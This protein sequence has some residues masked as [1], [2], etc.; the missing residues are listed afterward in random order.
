MK[1]NFF[2]YYILLVIAQVLIC[3]WF[4]LSAYVMLSILPA[5]V[6]CIPTKFSTTSSLLIAFATGFMVDFMAEGVIGLNILALVPVAAA[7]EHV[8]RFVFGEEPL[9][10]E[11][12]I[13]IRKYGIGKVIFSIVLVQS[14]F[15]LVY[16]IA[17]GAGARPF[18][19]NILRF[20]CSLLAGSALSVF[21]VDILTSEERR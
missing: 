7:R 11:D 15:L 21:I 5:L 13:S 19:F 2:L 3:E 8:I 12:S 14:L 1:Q 20:A 16:I 10:R 17:D 4:N 9:V 18:I 6:L